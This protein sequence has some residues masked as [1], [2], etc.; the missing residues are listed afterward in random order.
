MMM[1]DDAGCTE[2][3]PLKTGDYLDGLVEINLAEGSL[4]HE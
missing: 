4:P 1:H 2:V 3:R